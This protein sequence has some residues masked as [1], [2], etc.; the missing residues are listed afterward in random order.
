[1]PNVKNSVLAK[2]IEFCKHHKDDPMNDIEKVRFLM[3][4]G[5][6]RRTCLDMPV[7]RY[8]E[9]VSV[10]GCSLFYYFLLCARP[11]N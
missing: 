9:P 5:E 8:P 7:N 1:M 2:V 4:F 11:N 10:C 6:R 3:G